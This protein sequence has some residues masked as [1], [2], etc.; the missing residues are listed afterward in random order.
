MIYLCVAV[1]LFHLVLICVCVFFFSC[2]Y[3]IYNMLAIYAALI[4]DSFIAH[5]FIIISTFKI[6]CTCTGPFPFFF[7]FIPF[8]FFGLSQ[9]V[10]KQLQLYSLLNLKIQ[11]LFL[12]K[13]FHTST[14]FQLSFF[15]SSTNTSTSTRSTLAQS[16]GLDILACL[17]VVVVVVGTKNNM[18]C[19]VYFVQYLLI[20]FVIVGPK[21]KLLTT[22]T[23]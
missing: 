11:T 6:R 17:V 20:F 1:P 19:R 21:K 15:Q 23:Y 12:F 8:P 9:Q 3:I 22:L 10:N 4:A 2:V 14:F 7:Y 13:Y 5:F 16:C 18:G